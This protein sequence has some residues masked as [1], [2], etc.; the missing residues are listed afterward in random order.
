VIGFVALG[1]PL[2]FVLWVTLRL[3]VFYSDHVSFLSLPPGVFAFTVGIHRFLLCVVAG[4]AVMMILPETGLVDDLSGWR[5]V[6]EPAVVL[7]MVSLGIYWSAALIINFPGFPFSWA[8]RAFLPSQCL[9]LPIL[10]TL[11]TPST[12]ISLTVYAAIYYGFWNLNLSD[13]RKLG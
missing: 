11:R 7:I 9:L 1:L 4:V 2:L 5:H 3:V 13:R 8:D 6:P 12:F 10:L